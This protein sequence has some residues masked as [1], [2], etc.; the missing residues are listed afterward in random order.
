MSKSESTNGIKWKVVIIPIVLSAIATFAVTIVA[1]FVLDY[2]RT[3][4]LKLQYSVQNTLPFKTQVQEMASYQVMIEN[5]GTKTLDDIYCEIVFSNAQINQ[6]AFFSDSLL[7]YNQSISDGSLTVNISNLNP[8]ENATI[9]ALATS[10]Q[11]L[12]KQPEVHLRARGVT[13]TLASSN[14]ESG[15]PWY[16][17]PTVSVL[18]IA[19]GLGG[20][21]TLFRRQSKGESLDMEQ[22]DNLGYLC[23][24]HGLYSEMD[25]YYNSPTRVYYR[26]E[27]DRLATLAIKNPAESGKIK[28]VLADLLEYVQG[29]TNVSKAIV[30]YDIAKISKVGGEMAEAKAHLEEAKKLCP[31]LVEKRLKIDPV[32]KS[33]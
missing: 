31:K 23:G 9:Y 19:A 28:L 30:Q 29:I 20:A 8:Q 17:S 24:V 6:S 11:P 22:I 14:E 2:I 32:L 27:A 5:A 12:P 10:S 18:G 13:G 16:F 25:R 7:E 26:R 1:P 15:L 4:E 33:Q 21:A 3:P